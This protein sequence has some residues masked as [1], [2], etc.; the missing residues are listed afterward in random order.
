MNRAAYLDQAKHTVCNDR[1][2]IH[3]APENTMELIASYW[4]TYLAQENKGYVV[5]LCGA[6]VAVMMTLFKISRIQVN[7]AHDDNI[8]DSL[9]YMAIAGELIKNAINQSEPTP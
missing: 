4:N 1:Q 5:I 2:D 7:P 3:G 6:D 9:G 8:I